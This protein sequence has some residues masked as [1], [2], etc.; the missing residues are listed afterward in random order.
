VVYVPGISAY[1]RDFEHEGLSEVGMRLLDGSFVATVVDPETNHLVNRVNLLRR[2][3]YPEGGLDPGEQP[4]VDG[5]EGL[6]P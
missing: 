5:A 2:S 6:S 3:P 1:N 4:L